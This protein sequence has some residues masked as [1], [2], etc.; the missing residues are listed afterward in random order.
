VN[1]TAYSEPF[2]IINNAILVVNCYVNSD[3]INKSGY[4][5]PLMNLYI[6]G[7]RP[8]RRQAEVP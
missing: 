1:R 6:K 4:G 3:L 5:S 8:A 7:R 2:F